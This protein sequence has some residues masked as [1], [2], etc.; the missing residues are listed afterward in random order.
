MAKSF[1]KRFY[2]SKQ[3]KDVRRFTLRRDL[4]TCQQCFTNRASEV[5]H[6]IEL[7]PENIND[8]MITLSLDNLESLCHNCHTKETKGCDGDI[9]QGYI[10]DDDGQVAK[11]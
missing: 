9:R 7:T 10:F 1:S 6:V 2:S 5:H 8:P 3:W 4:Y 11:V